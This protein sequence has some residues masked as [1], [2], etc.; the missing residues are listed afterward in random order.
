MCIHMY[1]CIYI[2]KSPSAMWFRSLAHLHCPLFVEAKSAVATASIRRKPKRLQF[3]L[4]LAGYHT[5]VAVLD[6]QVYI[7]GGLLIPRKRVQLG[8]GGS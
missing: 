4:W 5:P 6:V 7:L 1:V 2:H 3:P 8:E